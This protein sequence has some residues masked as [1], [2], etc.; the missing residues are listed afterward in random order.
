MQNWAV[1]KQQPGQF[2][3]STG[4]QILS[5]SELAAGYQAW[6]KKVPLINFLVSLQ[7][8]KHSDQTKMFPQSL[9]FL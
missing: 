6:A 1:S 2:T 9:F 7:V 8:K 3:G 4:A 5:Q